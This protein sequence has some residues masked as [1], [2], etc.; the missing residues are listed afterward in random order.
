M[1]PHSAEHIPSF[2]SESRLAQGLPERV[3]DPAT[4]S[5]VAALLHI[6]DKRRGTEGN[7]VPTGAAT[8]S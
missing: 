3:T 6:A 2:V 7:P 1:S 5:V 4:L 8:A